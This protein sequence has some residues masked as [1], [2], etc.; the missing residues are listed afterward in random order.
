MG[1]AEK[2]CFGMACIYSFF[3]ITLTINPALFWG[4]ESPL[5][6]WTVMDDS[7]VWFGRALGAFMTSVTLA[8][9]YAGLP[10]AAMCKMYLPA[11]SVFMILF[12]YAAFFLT[13][14]GPGKNAILPINLSYTQVPIGAT[15]LILNILALMPKSKA[16]KVAPPPATRPP[17]ARSRTPTKKA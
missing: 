14:T 10:K 9:Y 4:P 8:P 6:Y 13:T 5:S 3:G 17:S 15:F 2:L 11:N 16:K 7:G 1:Y 12:T